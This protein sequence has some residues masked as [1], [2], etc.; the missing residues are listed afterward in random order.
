MWCLFVGR[1]VLPAL[2][3]AILACI[4]KADSKYELALND[5]VRT[6]RQS[7][8]ASKLEIALAYEQHEN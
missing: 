2:Q 1:E 6:A 8:A 3:S 4:H 7:Q 5:V